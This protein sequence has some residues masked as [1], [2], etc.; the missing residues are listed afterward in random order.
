MKLVEKLAKETYPHPDNE[1]L[2]AAY[3]RGFREANQMLAETWGNAAITTFKEA[4][5]QQILRWFLTVAET[6]NKLPDSEFE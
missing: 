4:K 1:A 6:V 3:E 2:R 5:D